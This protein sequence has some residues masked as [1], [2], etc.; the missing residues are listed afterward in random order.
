MSRPGTGRRGSARLGL[1]ASAHA[2]RDPDEGHFNPAPNEL[3]GGRFAIVSRLGHGTFGRVFACTDRSRCDV[4]VAVKVIRAIDRY[5]AA[6]RA[7][8][9]ILTRIKQSAARASWSAFSGSTLAP[10][11]AKIHQNNC[12]LAYMEASFEYNGH[13][14]IV[15]PKYGMSLLDLLRANNFRGFNIDWTRELSRNFMLGIGFLHCLGYIHTDIKLENILTK[16]KPLSTRVRDR[17]FVHPSG[18]ELIVIDLGSSVA[19][20]DVKKP[21]LVCTRQYR[22]PEGYLGIPYDQSLD[23][24]SCG[25]VIFELLTG[26]TLFRTHDSIVHLCMMEKL[27]GPMPDTVL[28]QMDAA[29][30]KYSEHYSRENRRWILPGEIPI[31][32]R[33]H[34]DDLGTLEAE[35]TNCGYGYH[36]SL[37]HL[38][39]MMLQWDARRRPTVAECMMHPF[40]LEEPRESKQVMTTMGPSDKVIRLIHDLVGAV[41]RDHPQ[42]A[43]LLRRADEVLNGDS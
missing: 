25:C 15:F 27:L 10:Y 16:H 3:L 31:Q 14:C 21:S 42:Y 12:N 22:P 23:I 34:Y 11:F 18:A 28:R 40:F 19:L 30:S 26:R 20:D 17:I 6:G 1:A 43:E 41:S 5:V 32:E 36:S 37:I 38:L 29:N 35:L 9:S 2:A 7:E 4:E 33:R 8:V 39:R 24:W 13:I